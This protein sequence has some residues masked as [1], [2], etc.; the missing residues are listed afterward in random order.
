[1]RNMIFKSFSIFF[2]AI[3]F[4]DAQEKTFNF[5]NETICVLEILKIKSNSTS[6]KVVKP[7]SKK[8]TIVNPLEVLHR[9]LCMVLKP[10]VEKM[11]HQNLYEKLRQGQNI[12]VDCIM[13]EIDGALTL[14]FMIIE[15]ID[16]PNFAAITS[17]EE[18]Q[19][20]VQYVRDKIKSRFI[21]A[22]E[23][24]QSYWSYDGIFKKSL[25]IPMRQFCG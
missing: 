1:M 19:K 15:N 13:N 24:C 7:Y 3:L 14:E 4:V 25:G 23:S 12:K 20:N 22:A 6:T 11:A 21:K 2:C 16:S 18:N 17:D 9:R 10:R 8:L 5:H